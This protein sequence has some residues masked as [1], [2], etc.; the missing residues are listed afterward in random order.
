MMRRVRVDRPSSHEGQGQQP[1]S[2]AST[3]PGTPNKRWSHAD[4]TDF[5][6]GHDSVPGQRRSSLPDAKQSPR[7]PGDRGSPSPRYGSRGSSPSVRRHNSDHIQEKY[8]KFEELQQMRRALESTTSEESL[9]TLKRASDERTKEYHHIRRLSNGSHDSLTRPTQGMSPTNSARSSLRRD[10]SPRGERFHP[11]KHPNQQVKGVHVNKQSEDLYQQQCLSA[12]PGVSPESMEQSVSVQN[13]TAM[14]EQ[15]QS[16]EKTKPSHRRTKSASSR[17]Q[18]RLEYEK[19][20]TPAKYE[21][22]PYLNAG[23]T[24]GPEHVL[25]D[26]QFQHKD[27]YQSSSFENIYDGVD[28]SIQ[29]TPTNQIQYESRRSQKVGPHVT[30]Q[31]T[32]HNPSH[33]QLSPSKTN[34]GIAHRREQKLYGDNK[35][36]VGDLDSK[37]FPREDV[38]YVFTIHGDQESTRGRHNPGD[39]EASR[40]RHNPGDTEAS[41][42]RHNPG[43]SAV[44]RGRHNPGGTEASR[45]RH[46]PA[47]SDVSRGRHNPEDSET[48]TG[49]HYPDGSNDS[50]TSP[51]GDKRRSYDAK[52][53]IKEEQEKYAEYKAEYA[54]RQSSHSS[55]L[56]HSEEEQR[57]MP[58]SPQS[59]GLQSRHYLFI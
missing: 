28:L 30:K 51:S 21:N 49:Y 7:R 20:Q 6:N 47:D 38:Q 55:D 29:T 19:S 58:F 31:P 56:S 44:S 4:N 1:Q 39:T 32:R 11:D 9:P 23:S 42:G 50:P 33:H 57:A 40:G 59:P 15:F 18:E 46:N 36:H 12:R 45:G 13:R 27:R 24:R 22:S 35:G 43:D 2:G 25:K 5:R 53:L 54:R 8:N 17:D 34:R 48:T 41:R 37:A 26:A 16:P 52:A 10:P 14:F 3:P